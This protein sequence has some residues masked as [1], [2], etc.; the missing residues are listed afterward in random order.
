MLAGINVIVRC[1]CSMSLLKQSLKGNFY[2]VDF[3]LTFPIKKVIDGKN[4][5]FEQ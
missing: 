2:S 1:M 4:L 5:T 3:R